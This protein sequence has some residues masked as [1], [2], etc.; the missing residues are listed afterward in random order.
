VP[1]A[2]INVAICRRTQAEAYAARPRAIPT[3]PIIDPHYRV[4]TDR[5]DVSGMVTVRPLRLHPIGLG[6]NHAR[7]Q[8]TIPIDDLHIGCWAPTHRAS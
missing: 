2:R 4:R 1:H 5:I 3:G 6:R 8:V 7:T